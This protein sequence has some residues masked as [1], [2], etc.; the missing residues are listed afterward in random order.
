M[1]TINNLT[2]IPPKAYEGYIWY[3]DST[4]PRVL[5]GD[6]FSFEENHRNPF[7][8][9]AL[10]FC[11]NDNTSIMVRHTGR[12]IISTYNLNDVPDNSRWIDKEYLPHKLDGIK[13]VCFKQLWVPEE[14]PLCEHMQVL[15]M[16][17]VIFTGFDHQ[18]KSI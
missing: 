7:V 13:K 2:E 14:D 11:R 10:L 4:L 16:K 17:A 5:R 9:E 1:D 18:P 6:L 3:S 15:N 8:A 12:Y